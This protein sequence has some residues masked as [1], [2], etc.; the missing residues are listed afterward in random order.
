MGCWGLR[1][2]LLFSLDPLSER[3]FYEDVGKLRETLVAAG[4]YGN[5][6]V[7]HTLDSL[8]ALPYAENIFNLL[9]DP[10][11]TLG[12]EETLRVLRPKDGIAFKGHRLEKALTK[13][14]IYSY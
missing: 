13:T 7:V 12:K 6:I 14:F 5:K 8:D 9:L 1:Q 11:N 2:P 10:E 4:L 3:G